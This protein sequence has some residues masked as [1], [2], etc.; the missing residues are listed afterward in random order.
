MI[1]PLAFWVDFRVNFNLKF[2]P[3]IPSRFPKSCDVWVDNLS[4]FSRNFTGIC[5]EFRVLKQV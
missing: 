2:Q 1:G 4:G 5:S 3:E